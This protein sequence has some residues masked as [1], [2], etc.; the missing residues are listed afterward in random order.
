MSNADWREQVVVRVRDT[1]CGMDAAVAQRIFDPFFTTKREA[2][3]GRPA[4]REVRA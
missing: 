2:G 1:G 4:G 3:T